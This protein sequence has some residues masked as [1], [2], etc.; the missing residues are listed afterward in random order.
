M[1]VGGRVKFFLNLRRAAVGVKLSCPEFVV[2]LMQRVPI[3]GCAFMPFTY[4][5]IFY[6]GSL[7]FFVFCS[8]ISTFLSIQ[9]SQSLKT[10]VATGLDRRE[11]TLFLGLHAASGVFFLF[12]LWS[13]CFFDDI[14][15]L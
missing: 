10:S 8:F 11:P 7:L 4:Q 2:L 3:A 15:S 5:L 14:L 9:G 6:C 13:V 1:F 12:F